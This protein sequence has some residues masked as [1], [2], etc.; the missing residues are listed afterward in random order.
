MG[1]P[2][3]DPERIVVEAVLC[4]LA[5]SLA[6]FAQDQKPGEGSPLVQLMF[7]VVAIIVL[8]YFMLY[9]PQKREQARRQEMLGGVKKNDR[10]VTI[11]GIYGVVMSVN[12]EAD[13]VSIRVDENANVKIRVTVSAIA[14]ILGDE[15]S[16]DSTKK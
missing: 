3:R 2:P 15:S 11:G 6:L 16:D 13:E 10:V 12:R 1:L 8:F 14:R 9:R 5:G 4:N 7:P